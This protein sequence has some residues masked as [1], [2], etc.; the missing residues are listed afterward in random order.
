MMPAANG[1]ANT[2]LITL[3]IVTAVKGFVD[4]AQ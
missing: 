2:T 1:A 3:A 4:L